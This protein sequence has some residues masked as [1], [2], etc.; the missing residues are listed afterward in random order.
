MS[1]EN[2]SA[3][4]SI[5]TSLANYART[6]TTDTR[7]T[8]LKALIEPTESFEYHT[9]DSTVK[10]LRQLN[11]KYPNITTLYT[12]G[13]SVE[14][15]DLWVMIISDQPLVHEP[16][17]PEVRY[18]GNIHGDEIVGRECLIRFIEY[19]C[20]NYRKHDYITKLIDNVSERSRF[21]A[22]FGD[23]GHSRLAFTFFRR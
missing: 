21:V 20:L 12:I 13:Q 6:L 9:Y 14:N 1:S 16:G 8:I 11:E 15:R 18:V 22:R 7:D 2:V 23:N 17:E 10:K 4:N 5:Y 3:V 19:L